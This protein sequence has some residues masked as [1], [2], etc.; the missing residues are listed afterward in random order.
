MTTNQ[1]LKKRIERLESILIITALHKNRHKYIYQ[2]DLKDA[3]LLQGLLKEQ[4][5]IIRGTL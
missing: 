4:K 2:K 1:N 5:R 3:L